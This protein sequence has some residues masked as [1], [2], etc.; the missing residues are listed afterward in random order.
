MK[1]FSDMVDS[2]ANIIARSDEMELISS[3]VNGAIRR[4]QSQ[5]YFPYDLKELRISTA[6]A[7]NQPFLWKDLPKDLRTIQYARYSTGVSAVPTTPSRQMESLRGNYYYAC[8]GYIVF[9]GAPANGHIDIAYYRL[10]P[11]LNYYADQTGAPA[12]YNYEEDKWLY[13]QKDVE[14]N[15]YVF[16][17]S[18]GDS[19]AEEAARNKVSNWIL[20]NYDDAVQAI[21][22][23][24]MVNVAEDVENSAR[25]TAVANEKIADF[26][27]MAAKIGDY[28]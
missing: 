22:V 17:E 5:N 24:D 7:S 2:V 16:V 8:A 6:G 28:N 15:R 25:W 21:A 10:L 23:R 14:R 18:L 1:T 19:D 3:A 27:K 26:R 12:V 9:S 11:R 20:E 4:L 13:R